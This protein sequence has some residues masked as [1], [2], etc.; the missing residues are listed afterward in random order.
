MDKQELIDVLTKNSKEAQDVHVR[1]ANGSVMKA[2][3]D[4]V[5]NALRNSYLLAIELD[6]PIYKKVTLPKEVGEELDI[7]KADYAIQDFDLYIGNVI[8]DSVSIA[9]ASNHYYV[10]STNAIIKLADAWRYGY[11]VEKEPV[12]LVYVSGTNKKFVYNK[13][14]D[15]STRM[16]KLETPVVP[17]P[18]TS[19]ETAYDKYKPLYEFT[20]AEIT[21]FG[22]QDCE[23]EE[24]TDD[25]MGC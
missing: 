7:A 4:G 22:L 21:K 12:S 3:Y 18:V 10:D 11:T 24:V 16:A 23:R 25:G 20:D 5:L 14:G 8:D 2:Y 6:E 1:A 9:R 13:R 15:T 19:Y 17:S